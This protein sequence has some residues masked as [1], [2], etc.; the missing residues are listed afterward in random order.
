M[1]AGF[2]PGINPVLSEFL[3]VFLESACHLKCLGRS[4]FESLI[5]RDGARP[6]KNENNLQREDN[7]SA[8]KL[9]PEIG[10]HLLSPAG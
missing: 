10:P 9:L 1:R 7:N 3:T 5:E 4:L 6:G 2:A 8:D